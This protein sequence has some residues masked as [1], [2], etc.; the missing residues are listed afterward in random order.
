MPPRAPS[1][2]EF[3][4]VLGVAEAAGI[5]FSVSLPIALFIG[6]EIVLESAG[7]E[8]PLLFLLAAAI[9]LPIVL[10][11]NELAVGQPGSGSAYRIAR[12]LG[13]APLSFAV[14]WLMLGGLIALASVMLFEEVRRIGLL[15]EPLIEIPYSKFVLTSLL[16]LLAGLNQWLARDERWRFRT[17]L[18]WIPG[19]LLVGLMVWIVFLHPSDF[20]TLPPINVDQHDL[21]ALTLMAAALWSIDLILNYRRQQKN[22]DRTSRN[23]S[24][25][26]WAGTALLCA[27]AAAVVVRYPSLLA[28]D[29]LNR[30]GWADRRFDIVF[31]VSTIVL[32]WLGLSRVIA[33]GVRL[34][35]TME[36]HG[37]LPALWAGQVGTLRRELLTLAHLVVILVPL[38]IFVSETH[39]IAMAAFTYLFATILTFLPY[40]RSSAREL[41]P[42][43]PNRLPLH[44]LFPVISVAVCVF[45]SLILPRLAI[46][47]GLGWLGIGGALF[48]LFGHKAKPVSGRQ[49]DLKVESEDSYEKSDFGVLVGIL[50]IRGVETLIT[51]GA[52]LAKERGGDLIVLRVVPQGGEFSL[53]ASR[54]AAIQARKELE[55]LSPYW[56]DLDVPTRTLVRI[57][58]TVASGIAAAARDLQSEF[59]LMG[60]PWSGDKLDRVSGEEIEEVFASTGKPLGV[61]L[62][63][64]PEEIGRVVVA[65]SGGPHA[66]VALQL[67]RDLGAAA[68]SP[69][70]LVCIES[71]ERLEAKPA[72]ILQETKEKAGLTD[73]LE[74]R[75]IEADTV[76]QGLRDAVDSNDILVMG[77]SVDRLLRQTVF[78]GLSQEVA[79]SRGAASIVVKRA[80]KVTRFWLRRVWEL[81]SG[82]MPQLTVSERSEIYSQMRHSARA[83]VDF[84]M[85]TS[86]ASA[87]ALF[88]L[89]LDSSA[90]II[91]AMLVA[92]LMS[93]ILATAQGI[94]QGNAY[95]IR[96][97]LTSTIK[98]SAT[99]V[100]V[101]TIL[102][103][104]LPS[105]VPTDEILARVEPN[106]LDLLVAMAAGGAAAYAASRKSVAAALPGV[107]ISVALV[108][109]L[110]VVGYGLG[111]SEFAIGLGALILFLTNLVGI[112]LVGAVIF[113]LLGFRPTQ[114]ERGTQVRQA[115]L[116]AVVGLALLVVPLGLTTRRELREQRIQDQLERTIAQLGDDRVQSRSFTI[117]KERDVYVVQ[118]R[119]WAFEEIPKSEFEDFRRKL[120][121]ETGVP[122]RIRVTVVRATVT[123]VGPEFD[124]EAGE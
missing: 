70:E 5:G 60:H 76:Q 11:Y 67:G 22:P 77:A 19:L 31:A 12:R 97:A 16:A 24:I 106:L 10:T 73:E 6:G 58:P 108:P 79:S 54:E 26:V 104:L 28:E 34:A 15:L 98:G 44:P 110:C 38:S 36:L 39:L 103:L 95:L 80:E 75:V 2:I 17:V 18:V 89:L 107:A 9:F 25:L 94:V 115:A 74:M 43:R 72:Q 102:T 61:V 92:P 23:A 37:L 47:L 65:T 33:R 35:S 49:D 45:F 66:V 118:G 113:L 120:E 88:G 32:I 116:V 71:R 52:A 46:P 53:E 117:R 64:I 83:S 27:A 1:A 105:V 20:S 93:P 55:K 41:N 87:I 69:V 62:G 7:A 3:S 101:A 114:A 90:V 21:A 96:R 85:L 56:S 119:V 86:L 123:D 50:D 40:A 13:S 100:C 30:L 112:V 14:G 48:V 91:G 78:A 82:P 51:T 99:S 42:S 63:E 57:A 68:N 4:R 121:V 59:V 81:L 84:Y 29:E 109:P 124:S 8:A 111:S 122:I